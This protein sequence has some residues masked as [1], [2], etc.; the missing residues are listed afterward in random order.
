MTGVS[1][2][3]GNNVTPETYNAIDKVWHDRQLTVRVA[4]TICGFN[5]PHE[6]E[7]YQKYLGLMPMGFGDDMMHFN[8]IGEQIVWA[9]NNVEK[10]NPADIERFYQIAKWAAARGYGLTFHCATDA[11]VDAILTVFERVD[12]EVSIKNLRWS[13]AHLNDASPVEPAP[14]ESA[15]YGLD[16]ARCDVLF[17]GR[18]RTQ[19]GR[20]NSAADASGGNRA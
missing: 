12:R 20:A 19:A 1:D 5:P 4:Y 15:G 14:D 10:P 6:V 9:I 2:P 16:D 7:E 18:N 3:C 13:I 8:G 17:G 11:A